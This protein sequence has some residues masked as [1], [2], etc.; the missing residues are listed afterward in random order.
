[1]DDL[2]LSVSGRAALEVAIEVASE[3]GAVLRARFPTTKQVFYKGPSNLVTDVDL[4]VERQIREAFRRE[5]PDVGFL[6]EESGSDATDARLRWIVDP[7]DGT[8][9]YAIGIP[10]FAVSLA[11]AQGP[12]VLLGAT[13]DPVREEMFH[14]VKGQGAFL[15]GARLSVTEQTAV[16]E[17]VLGFDIGAMD[18][19]AL[20]AFKLAQG[21]WPGIQAVR[22]MG[23]ATLG[24]AYTAAGRLD[25]YFHDT[26]APWDVA[27]GLLLVGEAGGEVRDR[28]GG[29]ATLESTGVVTSSPRLLEEFLRLTGS[30]EAG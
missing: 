13:Y 27:A 11:L 17:S 18:P 29:P 1:M 21:L 23:S 10:H 14:A 2:P 22:V 12:T 28:A 4:S 30:L 20:H 16:A 7:V 19:K 9:N 5:Y 15:N 8:R 26:V 3:A 6:G 25:I 24:L